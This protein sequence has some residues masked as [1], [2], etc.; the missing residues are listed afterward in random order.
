MTDYKE[1]QV[2]AQHGN[3][4]SVVLIQLSEIH[5]LEQNTVFVRLYGYGSNHG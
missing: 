3:Q 4:L 5:K 1:T 2:T